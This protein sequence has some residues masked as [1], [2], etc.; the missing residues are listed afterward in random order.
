[1]P[2]IS[3]LMSVYKE[4]I[5]WLQESI[6]SILNQ[7]F[8]DF[9]FIIILDNPNYNEAIQVVKDYANK[10]NRIVL[11]FN[12]QNMGL[13]KS[14][15][16]GLEIAQG[17][18]IARMDADDISMP[19]RFQK[20]VKFMDNHPAVGVCGGWIKLF[21][22]REGVQIYPRENSNM[23][24]FLD[25]PFAHPIVMIRYKVLLDNAI[26]YNEN[27]ITSQDYNL[28]VDLFSVGV[29]F[30][31]IQEP[32]L[33]YRYSDMQIMKT[34][35]LIQIV[36]GKKIRHKA[37][38]VYYKMKGLEYNKDV[39]WNLD[40]MNSVLR[41]MSEFMDKQQSEKFIY[42]SFLSFKRNIIWIIVKLITTGAVFR[43]S[44]LDTIRLLY[45]TLA[46]RDLA[47]F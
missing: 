21:G 12:E 3:V 16:K 47:K 11:L 15:N 43:F 33:L 13:T 17:E 18:Y 2:K 40:R 1:M 31:N 10:D 20:Q 42:Y 34:K 27:C 45:F 30:Y 38:S 23:C 32:L 44:P 25:S 46:N 7:T 41:D 6:D 5:E 26:C 35:S 8:K 22:D 39:E 37:L 36:T 19:D 28:W 29:K 14:L 4:P 9:E 24:L